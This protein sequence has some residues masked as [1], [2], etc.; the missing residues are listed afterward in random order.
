MSESADTLIVIFFTCLTPSLAWLG[1]FWMKD[2]YDREPV[3]RVLLT[4]GGGMLAGP[5]SIFLF[6]RITVVAFYQGIESIHLVPD[7]KKLLY[8]L[9]A[10]GLIEEMTKFLAFWYFVNRKK[11]IIDDPIDA[12]VYG[13]ATSLGFATI[14]NWYFMLAVDEPVFSRA[15]TLPFNHVLFSM[16]WAAAYGVAH[17]ERRSPLLVVKG[18]ALA[19]V[20]HGLYDYILFTDSVPNIAVAPLVLILWVWLSFVIRDLLER[21]PYR[22]HDD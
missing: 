5:V 6:E 18:L 2:E 20:F 4:F 14:E 7:F 22:P 11:S 19:I 16:F 13:A 17:C 9:F 10:I 8:A 12:I 1:Y 3:H 21:S 15:I